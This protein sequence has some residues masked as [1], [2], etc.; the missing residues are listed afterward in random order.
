MSC[1]PFGIQSALGGLR[2]QRGII[3]SV[4]AFY[5]PGGFP[6][7]VFALLLGGGGTLGLAWVAWQAPE[8][9]V[10][11][12]LD[13]GLSALAG[14]V[15]GGRMAY[16]YPH[17]GYFQGNILESFQIYRGG[18]AWPG[19]LL[20][21]VLGLILYAA[22]AKQPLGKLA[23]HLLPLGL[24]LAIAAWLACWLD[25]CAYGP[26]SSAWWA[27]AA[28]DEWGLVEP[29]LPLAPI[30]ALLTLAIFW[31]V[32]LLRSRLYVPGQAALL[33]LFLLSLEMLFVSF[34]RADPA[35]TWGILRLEAWSAAGIA[36]LALL[37]YLAAGLRSK[38]KEELSGQ[39]S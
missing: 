26:A 18:L 15:V 23:D 14:A 38:K 12:H 27:L 36:F 37:A 7:Y 32:E 11:H 13:A 6:V 29:R 30:G 21:G 5:L 39:T 9:M 28:R 25:G 1:I 24:T 35:P 4:T 34:L 16:I 22:L 17:W 19:A 3:V 20:G 8:K 31:L 2:T 10:L 33:A